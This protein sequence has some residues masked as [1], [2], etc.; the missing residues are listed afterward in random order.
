M[1]RIYGHEHIGSQ[2]KG[3]W[4]SKLKSLMVGIPEDQARQILN[5]AAEEKIEIVNRMTDQC[6]RLI[7]PTAVQQHSVARDLVDKALER[8]RQS[9]LEESS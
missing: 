9:S 7:N 5:A 1:T 2:D 4:V 3:M 8:A 6:N